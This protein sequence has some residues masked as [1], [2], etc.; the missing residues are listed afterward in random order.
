[1]S[2]IQRYQFGAALVLLLAASVYANTL[3]YGAAWDDTR[4]V[5]NSGATGGVSAI[6]GLLVSPY[7]ADVPA[8]RSP[9]RPIT[10]ASYALDWTLGGGQASF[11]HWTNV[12]LHVGVTGLLMALMLSLGIPPPGIVIGGA[13]FAAHPVH[14]EAVANLAGRAELLAALFG[15]LA[16]VLFVKGS[17]SQA[18]GDVRRPGLLLGGSV[19]SF[20]LALGAKENAVVVLPLLMM[21]GGLHV[22]VPREGASPRTK[23]FWTAVVVVAGAYMLM[24][25]AVLGTFTTH[26][27]APFI[28]TLDSDARLATAVANWWEYARLMVFPADL[29]VDYGPAVVLPV[30]PMSLP[31]LRGLVVMAAGAGVAALLWSRT[32]LVALGVAW[33]A[34]AVFPVSNLLVTIAQWLAE[35]FLYLPSAGIA[36]AIA[37]GVALTEGRARRWAWASAVIVIVL[38]A[39]RT[40]TRNATWQDTETVAATLIAEHPEAFR[41]QWLLGS[42]LLRNGDA[43][44]GMLALDRAVSLNPGAMELHLERAGWLLRLGDPGGAEDVLSRL[45]PRMHPDRE[46][47]LARSLA[48][49]GRMSDAQAVVSAGLV[50][51]PGDPGLQALS[52]SLSR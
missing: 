10:A 47:H 34:V 12:L 27:V 50:D 8:A 13:W 41:S 38:M 24:R 31:A 30:E 29:V 20:A 40:W 43:D 21:C 3:S 46:A 44:A 22:G 33:F 18:D 28:A 51:F 19:V 14:V 5:F 45:P 32:R 1:V 4:F 52:D 35:R 39:G 7:L 9:Y 16:I 6:P 2:D 23:L 25:R 36:L 17:S 42:A 48:A 11:F 15:V 37:A 26:D 49:Q